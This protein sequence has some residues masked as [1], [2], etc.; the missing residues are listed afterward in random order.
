MTAGYSGTPLAKKLGIKEGNKIYLFNAPDNYHS[1]VE[2]LPENVNETK[3][4]TKADL[5]HVFSN[6]RDEMDMM[7]AKFFP[8][9]KRD[10]AVWVSWYKKA[11]KLPTE[12]TEDIVRD[13]CLPMGFV[14]IKV[15]AVDE[16]WS[17]L[18]LVIRKE[19][20]K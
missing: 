17:G 16:I 2:P 8:A 6:R 3:D 4:I 5:L 10:A 7:L 13:I 19:L 20:R 1:L 14:D 12:I 15:C 11:A 9:I 18:K